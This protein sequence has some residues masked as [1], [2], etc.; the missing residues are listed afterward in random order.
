MVDILLS[1][2]AA[3]ATVVYIGGWAAADSSGNLA[4]ATWSAAFA[5]YAYRVHR[6]KRR[7]SDRHIGELLKTL[8]ETA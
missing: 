4:L 2:S 3:L 8:R 5:L 7:L 6:M 1:L